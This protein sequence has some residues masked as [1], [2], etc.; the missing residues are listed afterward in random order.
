[1]IL[2]ADD[3]HLQALRAIDQA[4]RRHLRASTRRRHQSR[5]DDAAAGIWIGVHRARRKPGGRAVE[6][7]QLQLSVPG[8]HNVLNALAA[9]AVGRELGIAWDDIARGLEGFQGA[10][11]RFQRRGEAN[12]VVGRR[13][14]RPPSRPRS[15]R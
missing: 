9:V 4:A 5:S 13:R 3:P 2:C 10:E 1:M 15:Q 12:G 6:L 7:G 14:L 11:R 8:R